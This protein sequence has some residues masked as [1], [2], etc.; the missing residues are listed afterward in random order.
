MSL[1]PFNV[2][3]LCTGNSAR[4]IVAESLLNHWGQGRFRGFSAGSFQ[5]GPFIR[6]PYNF[7]RVLISQPPICAARGGMSLPSP[8]RRLWTSCLRFA[9]RRR[10]SSARYGQ[11]N[12]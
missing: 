6:V 10:E 9:I 7:S 1:P 8:A 5:R 4:S 11:V 3:F 12:L 2:L